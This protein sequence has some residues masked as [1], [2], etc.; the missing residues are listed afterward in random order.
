M[1]LRRDRQSPPGHETHSQF[2]VVDSSV[3]DSASDAGRAQS[4]LFPATADEYRT[5]DEGSVRRFWGDFWA[6]ALITPKESCAG[7]PWVEGWRSRGG[8]G[9][10][11][12]ELVALPQKHQVAAMSTSFVRRSS[13]ETQSLSMTETRRRRQVL[14]K[15]NDC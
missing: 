8:V 12:I 11:R 10:A 3:P 13:S 7:A 6:N 4:S 9:V 14:T 2:H 1:R 15:R 5:A